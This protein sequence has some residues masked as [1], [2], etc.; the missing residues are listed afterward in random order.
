MIDNDKLRGIE[1]YTDSPSGRA[2][3]SPNTVVVNPLEIINQLEKELED[4]GVT[5]FK[6]CKNKRN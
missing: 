4:K 5:F 1:P 3:W 6:G 2:I